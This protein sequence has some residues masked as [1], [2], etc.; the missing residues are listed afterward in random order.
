MSEGAA[1]GAAPASS[2]DLFDRPVIV[3]SSP[4][5]GSTLLFETLA[6]APGLFSPGGESHWLI[7]DVPGLA[8]AE[9]GWRSNRLT[10]ED[11]TP[12]RVEQLAAAFHGALRDRDGRPAQGRVRMLEKTPKNAL[13]V[14]FFDAAF[15]DA[16]FVY[17]YRDVRQTLG[18]MIEAW[19]SGAFATYPELP[20]WRGYPWSLLL[21]PGW[22][23][24]SGQPLP[25]VV[26]RQWTITTETLLDD[27]AGIPRGRVRALDHGE[28]L[29]DPQPT[30]ER[31]AG[32]LGL[33]WDRSLDAPLPLSRTTLSRPASDKWRRFE[34][35]IETV[36]PL[37]EKAD[38]RA[39][40]F[41]DSFRS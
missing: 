41:L 12:E 20:G 23:E 1:A 8:P 13:R 2:R 3:V 16:L 10:A 32:R 24:L 19:A 17:L 15:P 40:D 21:V 34:S 9:R 11:A 33:G 27:L 39:R 29:A 7:E 31:L 25:A 37:V 4:R 18:S 36:W 30:M 26:A 22:E 35:H 14:P 5:S 6:Q 28:F 38:A